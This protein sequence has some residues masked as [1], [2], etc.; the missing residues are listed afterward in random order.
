M[1]N[2]KAFLL[3][4]IFLIQLLFFL[5]A[6]P[7]TSTSYGV[8][9][10]T[11]TIQ[12]VI[13]IMEENKAY[14]QII[15]SASA[16]YINSLANKY[17]LATDWLPAQVNQDPCSC[18]LPQYIDI[19]SGSDGGIV[20]DCT[21]TGCQGISTSN[22]NIFELMSNAG[23]TWKEYSESMPSNCY[24]TDSGNY[25]VHHTMAPFYSDLSNVCSQLDV[26]LGDVSTQTGNFYNDLSSNNLA[27]LVEISPNICDDMHTLCSGE[28]SQIAT[29]DAWLKSFLPAIIN[30][31][32]F[33]STIIIITWDNGSPLTSPVAT[34]IV[35]PSSLVKPG[36][37]NQA[38]SHYSFLSTVESIFNLPSLGRNDVS[39]TSLTATP[40]LLTGSSTTSTSISMSS[41]TSSTPPMFSF[42]GALSSGT[43]AIE[44]ELIVVLIL[45]LAVVRQIR[46]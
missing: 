28:T 40:M 22:T 38:L 14:S 13:L 15:G 42:L 30:S 4:F 1:K 45:G 34:I 10:G 17:A 43:G 27:N 23:L 19:S 16:P 12:H 26:P 24:M 25:F 6:T 46:D 11:G 37:Y 36:Q 9:S 3:V 41:S 2:S 31:P 39:A 33:S 21:G 20:N 29:G 32:E 44:L 8:S 35:G 5:S 7:I 18:S